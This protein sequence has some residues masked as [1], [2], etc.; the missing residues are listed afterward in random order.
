MAVGKALTGGYLSLAAT[1]CSARVAEAISR[2]EGGA[3]MHGPTYMANP[4]ACAVAL[5]SLELLDRPRLEERR[6]ADRAR[7][8]RGSGA[9][10]RL[11]GVRDVR[12]LGAIGVSQLDARCRRRGGDQA[13]V[14][15]GV[16]LRP[17]RDLVYTM[18]PY[19]TGDAGHRRRSRGGRRR[20][21]TR[22]AA[23]AVARA[24]TAGEVVVV[25]GTDTGVGKTVVTAALAATLRPR[26]RGSPSSS[27]HR[28]AWRRASPAISTRS[29]GSS[30][31][32][33]LHEFARFPDPLAPA[34]AARASRRDGTLSA[35]ELADRIAALADRDLVLV[36][37]A[38]GLARSARRRRRDNGRSGR[39]A[40][41]AGDRRRPR[42]ARDAQCQ[43]P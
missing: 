34:T 7:P 36:E 28:R 16:W 15:H 10:T 18:P 17:F 21:W 5:A 3:L 38:G 4:L 24:M 43:P 30:G 41:G 9:G 42:R 22:P 8:R 33:D 37:G 27:R 1:L 2:G 39:A 31:V 32:E 20:G 11:P 6:G 40:R 35:R 12:V 29:G 23:G 25:T 14:E 26:G 13:A 19:V